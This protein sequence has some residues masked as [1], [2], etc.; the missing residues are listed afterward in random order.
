MPA[1]GG[2]CFACGGPYFEKRKVGK[3]SSRMIGP[4]GGAL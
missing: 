3:R 4:A 1:A 2:F